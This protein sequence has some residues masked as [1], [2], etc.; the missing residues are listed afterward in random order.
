MA[1]VCNPNTWHHCK[2]IEF[3][4][5]LRYIV[6][7]CLKKK[8]KGQS[9]TKIYACASLNEE[10]PPWSWIF[11]YVFPSWCHCLENC[12]W[13]TLS[14]A[15]TSPQ[16]WHEVKILTPFPVC[17]HCFVLA[18]ENENSHLPAPAARP[19]ACCHAPLP[20]WALSL[21]SWPWNLILDRE[22]T[23]AASCKGSMDHSE[24]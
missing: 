3:K 6:R 10:C 5:S 20:F 21:W 22:A 14:G 12:S 19:R 16:G 11:E 13:G 23:N 24:S 4:I 17:S 7:A 18:F 1:H 15:S 2:M 9:K 8:K